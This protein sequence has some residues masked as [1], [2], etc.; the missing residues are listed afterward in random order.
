MAKSKGFGCC[1]L[2]VF[3][4]IAVVGY[5]IYHEVNLTPAQRAAREA[6]A[7]ARNKEREASEAEERAK[8]GGFTISELDDKTNVS[9]D[10]MSGQCY[11]YILE[12]CRKHANRPETVKLVGG[13]TVRPVA[14]V[15]DVEE[16]FRS[17]RSEGKFKGKTGIGIEDEATYRVLWRKYADGRLIVSAAYIDGN[18]IK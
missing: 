14:K 17:Y 10:E 18:E 8:Y 6:R 9:V 2:I 7:Q 3:G 4:F 12:L 15:Y 5:T 13:H 1:S 16:P 11:N